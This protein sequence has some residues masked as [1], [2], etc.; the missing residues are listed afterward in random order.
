MLWLLTSLNTR[1]LAAIF[2]W[3]SL[4]LFSCLHAPDPGKHTVYLGFH[5][6]VIGVRQVAMIAQ[7]SIGA[8]SKGQEETTRSAL[9]FVM[10]L[11]PTGNLRGLSEKCMA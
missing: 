2:L 5:D 6:L 10:I 1:L 3:F 8:T 7:S 4:G 9:S 11:G